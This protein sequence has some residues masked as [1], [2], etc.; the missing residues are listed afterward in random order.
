MSAKFIDG[1]SVG[2]IDSEKV[3][4]GS[5]E[6]AILRSASSNELSILSRLFSRDL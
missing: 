3:E 6:T 1:G 5:C 2:A 4:R